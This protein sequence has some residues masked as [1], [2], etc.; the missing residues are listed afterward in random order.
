MTPKEK[1]LTL[2]FKQEFIDL[3]AKKLGLK[4]D[5]V[6]TMMYEESL[7][8]HSEIVNQLLDL[9][10]IEDEKIRQ[11]NVDFEKVNG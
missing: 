3:L 5:S 7:K 6:K 8:K 4:Y 2:M 11:I 10:M 9:R 1:F